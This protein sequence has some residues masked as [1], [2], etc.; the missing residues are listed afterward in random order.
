MERPPSPCRR[1]AVPI[2]VARVVEQERH[3]LARTQGAADHLQVQRQTPCRPQSDHDFDARNIQA[4]AD[5]AAVAENV[6]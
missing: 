5:Q 4:F 6:D 2:G 3:R 1:Q